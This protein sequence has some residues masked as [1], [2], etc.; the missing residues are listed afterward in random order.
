MTNNTALKLVLKCQKHLL[1]TVNTQSRRRKLTFKDGLRLAL[2]GETCEYSKTIKSTDWCFQVKALIQRT[3]RILEVQYL[4][5][6]RYEKSLSMCVL[7]I[8]F[9]K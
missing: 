3:L 1:Q 2:Q 5:E 7:C 4:G 8:Y 6:I 9:V